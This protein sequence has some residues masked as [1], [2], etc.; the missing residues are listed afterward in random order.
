[1]VLDGL[2][3]MLYSLYDVGSSPSWNLSDTQCSARAL[4][5][6]LGALIPSFGL[7]WSGAGLVLVLVL[8]SRP[9]F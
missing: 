2:L 1:M 3:S 9:V 4:K 7:N 5:S 6:P 8:G